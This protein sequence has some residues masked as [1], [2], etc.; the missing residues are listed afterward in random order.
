MYFHIGEFVVFEFTVGMNI[1]KDS[2]LA[3]KCKG[4]LKILLCYG[5]SV[6]VG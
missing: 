5:S 3:N 4:V 1:C 2:N 6:N